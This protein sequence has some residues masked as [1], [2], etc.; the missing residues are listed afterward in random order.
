MSRYALSADAQQDL[1][2]IAE[3]IARDKASAAKKFIMKLKARFRYMGA[4][5]HCGERFA[6]TDG[7]DY[8]RLSAWNYV[9]YYRLS[10]KRVLISR[11]VHGY[12]D[13]TP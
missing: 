12:R 13:L 6:G 10:D 5:P 9:I 3:Y 7:L 1:E 2:G 4:N 8:R 11:I